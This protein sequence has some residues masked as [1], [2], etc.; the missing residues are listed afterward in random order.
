MAAPIDQLRGL[1]VIEIM[2]D[3]LSSDSS[4][5]DDDI[6]DVQLLRNNA[7]RRRWGEVPKVE[8][9]IRDVVD[10][11]SEPEFKMYIVPEEHLLA[12]LKRKVPKNTFCVIY[13]NKAVYRTVAH[14]FG[15]SIST[16]HKMIDSVINFLTDE[17]GPSGHHHIEAVATSRRDDCDSGPSKDA[18]KEDAT[19]DKANWAPNAITALMAEYKDHATSFQINTK[20]HTEIWKKISSNL[21]MN[22]Y[23]Y[24]H[25]QCENKFK[26]LKKRY[27]AKI[28]NMKS[29][30]TGAPALRFD[31]FDIFHEIFG[32]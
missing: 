10:K 24:T 21:H 29:K 11:Y 8:N 18:N 3:L 20:G 1:R 27:H 26:N 14:I 15:I 4:D 22:G 2:Q 28:D 30:Q 17:L 9:F 16:A 12:V 32:Q 19:N 31:Y 5:D 7:R 6:I 13:G 23:L 25:K